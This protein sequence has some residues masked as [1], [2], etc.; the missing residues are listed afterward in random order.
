MLFPPRCIGCRQSGVWLCAQCRK[1]IKPLPAPNCVLCGGSIP[2]KRDKYCARCR[3]DPL[4]IDGIRSAVDFAG[5]AREAVHKFKYNHMQALSSPLADI[6][7][8][9]LARKPLSFD[10]IVPVPLHSSRQRERGY[11][12]AELLA[13]ALGDRLQQPVWNGALRRVRK[14]RPQ[15]GLTAAERR[16][17][18]TA[19]FACV[20][21]RVTGRRVL[22]IDD[23]C[24][25]GATL[26]ACSLALQR[27]NV[28]SVWGLT[29]ARPS[30][31]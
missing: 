9:Y 18:V 29:L 23:V 26:E 20:E 10:V 22:L 25:T 21:T 19:A 27:Q 30:G 31:Q 6:M 3:A 12:Q 14:T 13:R 15:V 5:L 16:E 28:A 8:D 2:N 1:Q 7:A 24:T 17:N 4:Q 11:N